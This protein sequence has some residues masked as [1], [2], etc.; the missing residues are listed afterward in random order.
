MEIDRG[1][2]AGVGLWAIPLVVFGYVVVSMLC[3]MVTDNS[4]DNRTR[5][6]P[7]NRQDE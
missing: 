4:S 5:P 7:T 1:V 2:L 3:G 6:R